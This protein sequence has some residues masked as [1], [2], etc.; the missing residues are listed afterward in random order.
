M[1]WS[2]VAEKIPLKNMMESVG[3]MTFPRYGKSS[4]KCL[5]SPTSAAYLRNQWHI[6][7]PKNV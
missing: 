2:V 3:M 5:K 6:S 7:K 4:K 1:F